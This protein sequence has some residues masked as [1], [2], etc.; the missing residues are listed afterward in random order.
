MS[1]DD[2]AW[3]GT[4]CDIQ[5]FFD[6]Q[7][8]DKHVI[9]DLSL[10]G[11]QGR[12]MYVLL[13]LRGTHPRG[14]IVPFLTAQ[15]EKDLNE[16][17]SLCLPSSYDNLTVNRYTVSFVRGEVPFRSTERKVLFSLQKTRFRFE[18]ADIIESRY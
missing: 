5:S 14:S 9:N 18:T 3:S 4:P 8:G 1:K 11:Y 2:P 7:K 13:R 17:V 10:I 12:L 6:L 16:S 15:S